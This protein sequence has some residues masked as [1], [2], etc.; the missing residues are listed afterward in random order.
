MAWVAL[1]HIPKLGRESTRRLLS[2]LGSPSQVLAAGPK[3]WTEVAGPGAS[4]ALAAAEFS[5]QERTETA[6]V[7]LDTAPEQHHLIALGDPQYPSNLIE[8]SDPPLL[9]YGLGRLDTLRRPSIA[10]IGS[11]KATPLGLELAREFSKELSTAGMCIVSG[12]ALGVDG[13][14]HWGALEGSGSTIAVVGTGLDR[15]YPRQHHALARTVAQTGLILSEFPLGSPP[16]AEH[17]P[18]RNRIIAGLS[19]GTL[20]IEAARKSG[21]LITAR[22]ALENGREVYAIPGSV[23]SEQAQGCHQLIKDGACLVECPQDVLDGLPAHVIRRLVPCS[24]STSVPALRPPTQPTVGT[25][26]SPAKTSAPEVSGDSKHITIGG[27]DSDL[28]VLLDH[29]GFD[30]A[31]VDVLC[32][33]TGWPAEKLLVRPLDLELQGHV[34]RL[35]GG[36]IQR[37]GQA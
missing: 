22:L 26:P 16:R 4:A 5:Q 11:R 34:A 17:F 29:L 35:P 2:A 19:V 37:T 36:L 12:L 33:R 9:L 32:I 25:S 31:T 27:E 15:V 8:S 23:R 14:A 28:H 10:I 7:W 21:S 18:M 20:V 30:P 1:A 6:R 24:A 3:V 13:A